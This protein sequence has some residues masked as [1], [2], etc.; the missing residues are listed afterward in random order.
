[1]SLVAGFMVPHPPLIVPNVGRGSEAEVEETIRSYERVAEEIAE[2]KPETIVI[3]SPHSV[4]Y[5]D[6]FHISPGAHATGDFGN[7]RAPEVSFE[8]DYDERFAFAWANHAAVNE[9]DAGVL[10]ERDPHLDH[11]T[12]VPLYFITK[13]YTDF[14][15]VRIGLSGFSLSTHYRMG[16]LVSTV[17]EEL[18]RRVVYVA[19]GDLSHRLR[20]DG[21]YGF[22]TY[23]PVYDE[24]IM[25]VMGR[26]DFD[27]LMDFDEA[28]CNH[29][30]ECGHRS[31]VM[32]AGALD[33]KRVRIERLSHQDVTGVGYGI[34]TYHVEGEDPS[35]N[36]LDK[37]EERDRARRQEM[38]NAEDVYVRLA[39]KSLETNIRE[40]RRITWD[41]VRDEVI[42]GLGAVNGSYDSS[43]SDSLKNSGMERG[44]CPDGNSAVSPY[45][46]EDGSATEKAIEQLEHETAGAFVSLHKEGKLRGCI[47]T[48][49]A[50]KGCVADEI[51][52]NAISASTRDP[53]FDPVIEDELPYLEYSVDVLGEAEPIKSPSE[54]DVKR[55]GVIVTK[56]MRRGLLLPNLEGVDTVEEQLA[57]A[58]QKAGLTTEEKGCK[59][60]RFE[61]VRHY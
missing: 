54:L 5:A 43:E 12:M 46:T 32:L 29:A 13:K 4:M 11:G 49:S 31:F 27:E 55:Y 33:R 61:V 17:A 16:M 9:I 23:G 40:G 50:T 3:S 28:L 26:G 30:A 51:I 22:N 1:M 6:Y 37:W 57:I 52:E 58:K 39:R 34:C 60:Q 2:L 41:E 10:G 25:D 45:A 44:E 18:N 47:G 20:E 24:R 42:R 36:F 15:L 56:G 53:R 21:P 38:K 35:R 14:K 59:L 7:F 48:I 8:V 19:S